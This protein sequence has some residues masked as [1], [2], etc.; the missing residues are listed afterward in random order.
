MNIMITGGAGFIGSH[1]CD[2]LLKVS[3]ISL[4]NSASPKTFTLYTDLK[5]SKDVSIK[6]LFIKPR[7]TFFGRNYSNFQFA[8]LKGANSNR[9]SWMIPDYG[10]LDLTAGYEFSYE[11]L[12]MN[13]NF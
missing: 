1:L 10:V 6:G 4:I 3:N 9:E 12:K 8:G 5:S 13:L 2:V 11:G 7:Y